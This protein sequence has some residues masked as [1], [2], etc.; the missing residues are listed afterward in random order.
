MKNKLLYLLL[1]IF[2]NIQ[3]NIKKLEDDIMKNIKETKCS[4]NC[5]C[6]GNCGDACKC[7][8]EETVESTQYTTEG[9][10]EETVAYRKSMYSKTVKVCGN[11]VVDK[12]LTD[13]TTWD[14]AIEKMKA[15][16]T[17]RESE[18]ERRRSEHIW[19]NMLNDELRERVKMMLRIHDLDIKDVLF[20]TDG[21]KISTLAPCLMAKV[22]NGEEITVSL[23]ITLEEIH[24]TMGIK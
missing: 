1:E 2:E 12:C 9:A 15:A 23:G 10:S 6:G 8:K 16:I 20:T 24:D 22:I 11:D 7:K 14:E 5:G 4:G 18:N 19:E 17:L 3:K 13:S 21:C